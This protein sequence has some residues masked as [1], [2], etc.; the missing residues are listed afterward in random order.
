MLLTAGLAFCCQTA[1][2]YQILLLDGGDY[3]EKL[4]M[5]IDYRMR[6]WEL[7]IE[8]IQ[9]KLLYNLSTFANFVSML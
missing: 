9:K 2:N 3:W 8:C 5:A 6:S 7:Y 1:V 4:V